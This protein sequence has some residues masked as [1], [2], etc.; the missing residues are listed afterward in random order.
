MEVESCDNY[1]DDNNTLPEKKPRRKVKTPSQI[2]ALEKLYEE[3]K[4]PTESLKLQLAES[5][6]LTEKQISGWFCHRRLKDKKS[7]D[8]TTAHGKQDRSSGVIQDRG[9]GLRQDS[10]GSTKQG[11]L[12]HF[13][14]R[15]VESRRFATEEFPGADITNELGNHS[16]QNHSG[17]DDTSSGSS[18]PLQDS[19]FPQSTDPRGVVTSRNL[20]Q[21]GNIVPIDVKGSQGRTGPSGYLK[22]KVQVENVA[23]TSVKRQLGRHYRED[24]PP[25]G[26]DFDPLPP[27]AFE[28]PI[29]RSV[30][31]PDF[32]DEPKFHHSPYDSRTCKQ[33]RPGMGYE[34]YNS[35]M[36]SH[37][38]GLDGNLPFGKKSSL[39]YQQNPVCKRFSSMAMNE[40]YAGEAPIYNN[41][42]MS[43]RHDAGRTKESVSSPHL[44]PYGRKLAGKQID[45]INHGDVIAQITHKKRFES[46][47]SNLPVK[48]NKFLRLEERG[49]SRRA[50]KEGD[51]YR[52]RRG[53]DDYRDPVKVTV[54]SANEIRPAKRSREDFSQQKY[55]TKAAMGEM[56]PWTNP[57]RGSLLE[58]PSSF[59]ED[60]T[61]QTSSSAN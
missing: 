46:S 28:S 52:E 6:G 20:T 44:L 10:C 59:S 27:G 48:H 18:S 56:T 49:L 53:I 29:R 9:S 43:A 21:K 41:Y 3:H 4:Y 37:N 13:D 39:S 5:V 35:M 31:E 36:S 42:E 33:P 45:P 22:V 50:T 40:D 2:E 11:E 17:T 38:S 47:P 12:R 1:S 32:V 58:V 34:E 61:G 14:P 23:I 15:E 26:I 51:I 60:E 7:Q 8:N 55:A 30:E 54:C 16:F 19:Y 25:L 57:S 24:G